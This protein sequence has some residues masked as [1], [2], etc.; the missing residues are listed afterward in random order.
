MEEPEAAEAP[1]PRLRTQVTI[2][3]GP[4]G[5]GD[6]WRSAQRPSDGREELRALVR[7]SSRGPIFTA[8]E[9]LQFVRPGVVDVLGSAAHCTANGCCAS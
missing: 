1:K 6:D 9:G 5:G 7:P 4:S 2:S 8:P 3:A